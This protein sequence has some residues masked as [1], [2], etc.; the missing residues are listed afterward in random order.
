M[1]PCCVSRSSHVLCTLATSEV[2][3]SSPLLVSVI[4]VLYEIQGLWLMFLPAL[5]QA[6]LKAVPVSTAEVC[7][8]RG[9]NRLPQDLPLFVVFFLSF[10]LIL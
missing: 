9:F 8:F 1:T 2:F 4:D 3:A 7:E 10:I 5:T 6:A